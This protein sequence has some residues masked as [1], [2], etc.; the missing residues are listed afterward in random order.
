MLSSLEQTRFAPLKT[1]FECYAVL[2]TA[3][4]RNYCAVVRV[5][6]GDEFK[7]GASPLGEITASGE[8]VRPCKAGDEFGILCDPSQG[9][10]QLSFVFTPKREEALT[11]TNW[12][13][14]GIPAPVRLNENE[15]VLPWN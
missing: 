1:G 11:P 3:T 15:I 2:P 14:S 9:L 8:R 12:H 10:S 6:E 13:F 7:L 5:E 4:Q